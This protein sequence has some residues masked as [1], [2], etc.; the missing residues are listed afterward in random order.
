LLSGADLLLIGVPVAGEVTFEWSI[1]NDPIFA[2]LAI[3]HQIVQ[4]AFD[5]LG[6]IQSLSSSNGLVLT[7]GVF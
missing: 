6:N 2:G 5:G 4:V 3:Y 1:V 7:V